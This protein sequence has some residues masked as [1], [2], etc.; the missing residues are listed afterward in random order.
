LRYVVLPKRGFCHVV[1]AA[2]FGSIS[3]MV[4]KIFARA[5]LHKSKRWYI[6]YPEIDSK[7]GVVVRRRQEFGLNKMPDLVAREA[8]GRAIAE[9]LHIFLK[10]APPPR[11]TPQQIA[12]SADSDLPPT[13]AEAVERAFQI[14]MKSPRANTWRGYKSIKKRFMEWAESERLSGIPVAEFSRRHAR[15]YFDWLT[16]EHQYSGCTINNHLNHLK[17]L[18]SEMIEREMVKECAFRHIKKAREEKKKRR[19]FTATERR[20]VAA[21]IERT[22]YWLFRAL[23]LQY[24]CYIRPVEITRLRFRD[25]DLT[26]GTVTVQEG[27]A[28]NW[29]ESTRTIPTSVMHY[30][31]DGKFDKYPG[32]FYVLGLKTTKRGKSKVEPC[33]VQVDDDQM[34]RRHKKVLDRL[35][36]EGVL[37]DIKGLTWYSWKDTGISVHIRSTSPLAT[38]D[39]AGHHDLSVTSRYYHQP[40]VN[41][42]YQALPNDLFAAED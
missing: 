40:E 41:S 13:L 23:L 4:K 35:K 9:N 14:K 32:N 17:A 38:K 3:D 26:K 21:E 20:L 25:F 34:Y 7:T 33:T 28:K 39:Q 5:R 24:Y 30:F 22:D 36:A 16:D 29:T 19:P 1:E 27:D 10:N 18:W 12:P 42:E 37:G 31:R 15:L 11:S 8:A 6:E 2:F